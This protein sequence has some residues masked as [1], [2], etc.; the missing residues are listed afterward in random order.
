MRAVIKYR[1]GR[2]IRGRE[3][4]QWAGRVIRGGRGDWI[5]LSSVLHPCQHSIGYMGLGDGFFIDLGVN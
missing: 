1:A 5:G 4:D 2:V 3:G